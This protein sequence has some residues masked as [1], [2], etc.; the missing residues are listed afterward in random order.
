M[1][2]YVI[3]RGFLG[4]SRSPSASEY[5][6]TGPSVNIYKAIFISCYCLGTCDP[7]GISKVYSLVW[8]VCY[9]CRCESCT[10]EVYSNNK[11]TLVSRGVIFAIL[12]KDKV[13][14]V[15]NEA[16]S[17]VRGSWI[18]RSTHLRTKQVG[19]IGTVRTYLRI[20]GLM[21]ELPIAAIRISFIPPFLAI[22][23]SQIRLTALAAICMRRA[24]TWRW[25]ARTRKTTA[26]T[27][28]RLTWS[29]RFSRVPF[30]QTQVI[31]W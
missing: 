7:S 5:I 20:I 9:I 11:H 26:I 13:D 8:Y 22:V 3:P 4:R 16:I 25:V 15:P 2:L 23:C 29:T 17:C 28:A 14:L 10:W 24:R 19:V 31:A 1:S 18:A 12:F 6:S 27:G 21:S 30:L